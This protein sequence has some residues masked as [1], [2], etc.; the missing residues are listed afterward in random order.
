MTRRRPPSTT[1]GGSR[2]DP[3][4]CGGLRDAKRPIP[5][6]TPPQ[7]DDA[8]LLDAVSLGIIA[9]FIADR[10]LGDPARYHPVAGF[11]QL[12][13]ALQRPL[14]QPN[15]LSGTVYETILVGGTATL[16]ALGLR[17]PRWLRVAVTATATW[18]VLGGRT[19]EREARAVAQLIQDDDLA[20]ARQRVRSLVGR[21]PTH[22]S[23]DELAR[24]C[25]ESLAENTSDAVVAPLFWG[26][27]AGVPGLI[28]YRAINTLDAMVGHRTPRWERFGWA[29]ARVDDLANLL[30]ARVATRLTAVLSGKPRH[31]LT[32]VRRDAPKHP[33]PNG[34]QI[35]AAY[36]ATLEVQLGGSNVYAGRTE[37][38][39]TLGD[40]RPVEL[41]DVERAAMLSRRLSWTTLAAVVGARTIIRAWRRRPRRS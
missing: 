6:V 4:T 41:G 24:A 30:P 1:C 14:Y 31:V 16:G 19:L 7:D 38:R 21:D 36:A 2:D 20:G 29:A 11:G 39:G 22:L 15:R 9:G 25:V 26:A 5:Y 10:L 13:T 34:G 27:I 28:G 17:G 8:R 23:S 18:A 33:S 3:A 40:G 32:V 12:A 37:D 35:E